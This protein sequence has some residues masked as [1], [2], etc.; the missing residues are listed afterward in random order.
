MSLKQEPTEEQGAP[1]GG[2]MPPTQVK[3][4]LLFCPETM[5]AFVILISSVSLR[6]KLKWRKLKKMRGKEKLWRRKM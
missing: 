4:E 3:E 6:L 1:S 2:Q 5:K